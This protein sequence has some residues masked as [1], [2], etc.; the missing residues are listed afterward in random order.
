MRLRE[1]VTW[2]EGPLRMDFDPYLPTDI[3][4]RASTLQLHFILEP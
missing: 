2:L 4:F 1:V 3:T